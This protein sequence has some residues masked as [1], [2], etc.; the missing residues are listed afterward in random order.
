MGDKFTSPSLQHML[1]CVASLVVASDAN[2]RNSPENA[3][4]MSDLD[5]EMVHNEVTQRL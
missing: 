2:P 5:I 4:K 1:E 3:L